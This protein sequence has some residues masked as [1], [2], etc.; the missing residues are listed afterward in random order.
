MTIKS[1]EIGNK[2]FYEEIMYISSN[3]YIFKKRP[4]TK[5]HSLTKVFVFYVLIFFIFFLVFLFIPKLIVLSGISLTICIIYTYL[6]VE[7][8]YKINEYMKHNNSKIIIDE[9]GITNIHE[10]ETVTKLYWPAIEWI[11]INKYSISFL[12]KNFSNQA[13]FVEIGSKEKVLKALAKYAKEKTII[14]NN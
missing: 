5:T 1:K 6:L 11:I 7:A 4:K 12:P 3:Y 9:D 8:H 14:N 13:I 10:T 2:K